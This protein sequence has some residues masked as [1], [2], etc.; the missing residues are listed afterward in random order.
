MK[1]KQSF[2]ISTCFCFPSIKIWG[3]TATS[4]NF[5]I[6]LNGLLNTKTNFQVKHD[7]PSPQLSYQW[8]GHLFFFL[9]GLNKAIFD[10]GQDFL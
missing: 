6:E 7:F 9:N 5:L 4:R 2:R 8:E 1:D 3:M 10:G